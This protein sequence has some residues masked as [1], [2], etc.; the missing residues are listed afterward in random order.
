M[1][2]LDISVR[3]VNVFNV[4]AGGSFLCGFFAASTSPVSKSAIRYESADVSGGAET[5]SPSTEL[6]ITPVSPRR[7]P[8][9]GIRLRDS[10]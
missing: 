9:S 2:I 8:G 5:P 10:W 7:P 4:L 3:A 1:L 6:T